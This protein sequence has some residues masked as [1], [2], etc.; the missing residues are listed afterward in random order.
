MEQ[1]DSQRANHKRAMGHLRRAAELIGPHGF[2][3]DDAEHS[4]DNIYGLFDDPNS[5]GARIM[6]RKIANRRTRS[7]TKALARA[8]QEKEDPAVCHICM[9]AI[10]VGAKIR[11]CRCPG[12]HIFHIDCTDKWERN[13][14]TKKQGFKC[15]V[16]RQVCYT[17]PKEDS[18]NLWHRTKEKRKG[19]GDKRLPET[20]TRNYDWTEEFVGPYKSSVLSS[21]TEP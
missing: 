1:L 9:D 5:V 12:R 19:W 18:S 20:H 21:D 16:C 15:P 3:A 8:V 7:A 4:T 10:R 14:L 6:S 2:G 13:D 11:E 17:P